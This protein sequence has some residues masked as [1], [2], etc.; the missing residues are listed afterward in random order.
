MTFPW[1]IGMTFP[2]QNYND[3]PVTTLEWRSRETLEWRSVDHIIMTF[4]WQLYNDVPVTTLEWPSDDLNNPH[5]YLKN[6]KVN[7][8]DIFCKIYYSLTNK[9]IQCIQFIIYF[10]GVGGLHG[11]ENRPQYFNSK[12]FLQVKKHAKS[13]PQIYQYWKI[14]MK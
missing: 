9:F 13:T 7:F 8:E 10:K 5:Q 12:M 3:V 14:S 4:R 2:W 6:I 11:C 1:N